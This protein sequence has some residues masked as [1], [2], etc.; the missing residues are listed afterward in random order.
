MGGF[1]GLGIVSK[2]VF[3]SHS[4]M[5]ERGLGAF[6]VDDP[7]MV[8]RLMTGGSIR[9]DKA[10]QL[11][12]Y[13]NESAIGP[14]VVSEVEAFLSESG[15]VHRRFGSLAGGDPLF[16]R[17]LRTGPA[18]QLSIVEQV[19]AWMRANRSAF[20]HTPGAQDQGNAEQSSPDLPG[21]NQD[22]RGAG[23]RQAVTEGGHSPTGVTACRC[24]FLPPCRHLT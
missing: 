18:P 10:D 9:H 12:C 13:M 23:G 15:I 4:Q 24:G 19:Q 21:V 17:R 2:P 7:S 6:A 14:G 5:N 8:P 22:D 11:L 20:E 16:V 3:N 1:A